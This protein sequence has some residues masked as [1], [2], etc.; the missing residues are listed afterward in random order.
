MLIPDIFF[1]FFHMWIKILE[2]LEVET[3]FFTGPAGFEPATFGSGGR[4][5]RRV[6]TTSSNLNV[7]VDSFKKF[8][9][10]DLQLKPRTVESHLFY[11]RKLFGFVGDVSKVTVDDLRRF[12]LT[13]KDNP[14]TY[15]NALKFL[16]VF[17]RDFMGVSYL[18]ATFRFPPRPR[19]EIVLPGKCELKMF[20]DA[21][22]T[23]KD[24]A[25][26]LMYASSG[27]RRREVL[28]L[29]RS[30]INLEKRIIYPIQHGGRGT[31][32]ASLVA[33]FNVE[34]QQVLRKYLASRKNGNIKLFPMARKDEAKIWR[35]TREKTGLNITP[36]ILREWF[37]SEM[38]RLGVPDR[39]VDAFQGRLPR[40]VL[41][42][43]Y[44][45]YT[46]EKL[47]EIYDK[48]NLKVLE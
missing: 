22:P 42:R 15:A 39:Y 48:A 25:L 10:V 20:Y 6:S 27:L 2:N 9:V 12:L 16:K 28:T 31:K 5:L 34:T 13:F 38:G 46:P 44:T 17:Y 11:L 30:D 26:F 36:Q 18:V 4:N 3:V 7:L 21:L 14:Y 33:F 37:S 32:E 47:K 1:L 29:K 40:S 35:E 41:A 45:D 19:R 43:H 8:L 23:L 24:K